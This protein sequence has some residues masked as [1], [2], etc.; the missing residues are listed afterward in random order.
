MKNNPPRIL[1]LD[2]SARTLHSYSRRLTGQLTDR[3]CAQHPGAILVR[4]DLYRDLA[5]VSE[6]MVDAMFIR[7]AARTAEQAAALQLSDELVSE[8][9][10]SDFLVLGVPIYNFH[11]PASLK[12]YIDMVTRSGLSFV[13]EAG[14]FRGLIGSVKAFVVVTSG[15]TL[16]HSKVDFVSAYLEFILSFIG[17]TDVHFI[18]ATGLNSEGAQ[19]VMARAQ[20]LIGQLGG[21]LPVAG[22]RK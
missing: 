11:I 1:Q 4:R 19:P 5:F 6:T 8:L 15:G 7:P 18:D 17:I 16:L 12:A 13:H 14:G 21:D 9:A 10:G 3:L 2:A 20:A 22:S